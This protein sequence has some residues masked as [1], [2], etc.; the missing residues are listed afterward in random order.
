MD[1]LVEQFLRADPDSRGLTFTA[2]FPLKP[3]TD[4]G[5]KIHYSNPNQWMFT[6]IGDMTKSTHALGYTY[7]TPSS[8]DATDP[9][10]QAPAAALCQGFRA[11]KGPDTTPFVLFSPVNCIPK[12]YQIDMYAEHK[13]KLYYIGRETRIGMGPGQRGDGP[14]NRDRCIQRGVTRILDARSVAGELRADD[15]RLVQVV[16]EIETGRKVP[17]EEWS[18]WGGFKGRLVWGNKKWGM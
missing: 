1:R 7:G 11:T 16:M 9:V 4:V 10:P 8:P 5:T 15:A 3:F 6:T 2:N 14:Q 18:R 12:S 17:E 13:S